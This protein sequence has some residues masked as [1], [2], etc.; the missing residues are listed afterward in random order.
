[1]YE[2]YLKVLRVELKIWK[3]WWW[4]CI[5]AVMVL[6]FIGIFLGNYYD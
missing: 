6:W 3:H 5:G 1:M 4:W 2:E